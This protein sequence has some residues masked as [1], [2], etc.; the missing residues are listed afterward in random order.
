MKRAILHD[1]KSLTIDE[2]PI[3]DCPADGLLMK[4]ASCGVCATD[5]KIYNY[6]HHKIRLPRVLGHELAGTVHAVGPAMTDRF[7]VGERIAVCAVI[8]CG[9][10]GY[11][12]HG[13]P[14]MC[15]S[16]EAFGY[17]YDGGYQE[18]VAVP[19][20]AIRCSGV[21]KLPENVGFDEAAVA[22]LLACSLNG[23]SLSDFRFGQSVL[24]IGSGP[25]GLL[26]V[27]LAASRGCKPI[28]LA[29]IL[30]EKLELAQ[31]ICGDKLLAT[32]DSSN[33]ETFI[34]QG[35]ELTDGRGFDQVMICCGAAPAQQASLDLV[36]KLGCVNFFGGLPKGR[37][38]VSLDTNLIHYKQCRVVGTHGSSALE[39]RRA[40]QLIASGQIDLKPMISKRLCLEEL[41][42]VLANPTADPRLL[43]AVVA[44][45]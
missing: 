7:A 45:D 33:N 30:P 10:C 34:K 38:Q 41:E 20:K 14:S 5:V 40:I 28:V 19:N 18:Y 44:Y 23:Q 21:Q 43:K 27:L 3:P 9:E 22:E 37:S 31:E 29:D 2:A 8:N 42:Q 6:G 35:L 25:V 12:L 39:N 36:A 11:C 1:V 15:E 16:L 13:Q 24:V 32:L 26:H 17:H 4:V